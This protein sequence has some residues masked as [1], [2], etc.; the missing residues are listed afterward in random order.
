LRCAA[1]WSG[2]KSGSGPL[3]IGGKNSPE[4]SARGCKAIESLG[5]KLHAFYFSF[6][7]YD[8]VLIAEAPSNVSAAAVALA[9]TSA[10][11][12]SKFHTTTLMTTAESMEAMKLAQK[13]AYTPPE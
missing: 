7:D 8:A 11:L 2:A 9:T 13:V 6:G 10:G 1:K 3:F 12:L 5:G 4:P